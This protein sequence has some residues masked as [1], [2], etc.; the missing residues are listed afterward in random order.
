METMA[1]TEYD[2]DFYAWTLHSADLLRHGK[3]SEVDIENVAEEI[4]SMGRRDKRE[5]ISR[6]AVLMAHLLKWTFQARDRRNSWLYTIK[7][8]RIKVRKLLTESPS[9]K[10]E[11][12][13]KVA[14][15]YEEAV[16]IAASETGLNENIFP[17]E[18]PFTF[19]QCL[20]SQFFPD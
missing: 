18:F 10:H 6:L 16:V 9:L 1:K 5:L 19:E 15:A 3:F 4:E 8:Q 12:S 11:L 13:L 20:D 7:E 2:R 14:E 17:N